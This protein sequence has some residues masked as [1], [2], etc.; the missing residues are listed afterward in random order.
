MLYEEPIQSRAL[1]RLAGV[2]N[3]KVGKD[4]HRMWVARVLARSDDRRKPSS[5]RVGRE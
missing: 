3:S 5:L 4:E 1:L 2:E